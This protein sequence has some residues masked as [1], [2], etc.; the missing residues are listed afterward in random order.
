[1]AEPA[2]MIIPLLREMRAEKATLHQQTRALIEAL[3]RRFGRVEEAQAPYR[4][5]LTA[6]PQSLPGI[7]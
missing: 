4:Q 6:D 1:M 3:D 2:D 7:V 5:A